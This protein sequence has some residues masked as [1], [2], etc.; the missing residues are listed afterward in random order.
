MRYET[1]TTEYQFAHGK[2]PKGYGF[3]F[4]EVV[5]NTGEVFERQSSGTLKDA[6]EQV[7]HNLELEYKDARVDSVKVLP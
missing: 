2:K 3:W 1:N 7:V 6:R 4:F 5:L